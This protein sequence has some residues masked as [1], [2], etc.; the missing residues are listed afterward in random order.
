MCVA[1]VLAVA[2]VILHDFLH[3]EVSFEM[4]FRFVSGRTLAQAAQLHGS[5]LYTLQTSE[6]IMAD[7]SAGAGFEL[8]SSCMAVA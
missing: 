7:D 2:L 1:S 8:S 3:S 4:S 5:L 6:C